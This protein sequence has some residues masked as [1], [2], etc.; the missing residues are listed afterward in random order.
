[1]ATILVVDD[2]PMVRTIATEL[3][4]QDGHGIVSAP[5]GAAALE[6]LARTPVDLVVLDMLMPNKDGLETIMELRKAGPAPKILAISSGG[7]GRASELLRAAAA[8]GADATMVKPRSLATFATACAGFWRRENRSPAMR[9]YPM[10]SCSPP[11]SMHPA[12]A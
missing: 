4:E 12:P 5:D 9:H 10:P 1:M 6:I 2:D 8:F 3:L 11:G 7:R